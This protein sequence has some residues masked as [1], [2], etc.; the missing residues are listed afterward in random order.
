MVVTTSG[1]DIIPHK[2]RNFV[3]ASLRSRTIM[4]RTENFSKH[5]DALNAKCSVYYN[6]KVEGYM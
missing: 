5:T 3:N 6:V 2:I 1:H 4:V